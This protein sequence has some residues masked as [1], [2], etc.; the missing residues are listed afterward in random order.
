MCFL[1]FH[2]FEEFC[3]RIF[4]IFCNIYIHNIH[5]STVPRINISIFWFSCDRLVFTGTQSTCVC[6]WSYVTIHNNAW[7][8][9]N[10]L[11]AAPH[12]PLLR[13]VTKPNVI[14]FM[15]VVCFSVS[16][17]SV[18]LE[19]W[20]YNFKTIFKRLAWKYS[21]LHAYF[22]TLISVAEFPL[23]CSCHSTFGNVIFDQ[24]SSHCQLQASIVFLN[25]C[26]IF[27]NIILCILYTI[28]RILHTYNTLVFD[29][30]GLKRHNS[31]TQILP[32]RRWILFCMHE[33]KNHLSSELIL[34]FHSPL[35]LCEAI[36]YSHL[37]F[38]FPL[39][40]YIS[41]LCRWNC[42]VS[43]NKIKKKLDQW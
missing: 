19:I 34:I 18:Q 7:R 23:K 1:F 32:T 31:Y 2:S 14:S 10:V 17:V 43:T 29:S 5:I 25:L 8:N 38:C 27:N 42:I 20:N 36:F 33:P 41:F 37:L 26:C 24:I 35:K 11:K 28:F 21:T 39:Y 22:R 16:H 40:G 13:S 3:E 4:E 30:F 6:C 9:W 15:C 12:H